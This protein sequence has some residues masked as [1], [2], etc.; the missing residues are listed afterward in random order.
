MQIGR[1]LL[2]RCRYGWM[3]THGPYIGKCFELY[4][5]YSEDEVRVFRA[6]VRAGDT[7]LDIGA[8]IGD[9]TV[10]LAQIVGEQGRVFAFESHAATFNVLCGNLALNGISNVRPI[11]AFVADS[12][13]VDTS[14]PWGRYGFVSEIWSAP[15]MAIDALDLQACA[16]IKVDVDGKELE[17][18]RSGRETITRFRPIVYFENDERTRSP[19][20]LGHMLAQDYALFWHR[21]PIFE[22]DNYF[23]NPVNHWAPQIVLSMMILAV[24]REKAAALTIKLPVVE[25]A[26]QW[27]TEAA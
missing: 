25:H 2:L 4:G 9:L 26:D 24:P 6:F 5:Q 1:N 22:P 18:L 8:N 16:F 15:I 19:A 27:W 10:P 13:Q 17:V 12:D 23:G 20:L 7:V 21:A 3:L 14:G 11:N